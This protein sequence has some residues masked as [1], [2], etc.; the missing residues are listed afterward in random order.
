MMT[1]YIT[2]TSPYARMARVMVI[3]AGLEDRVL[4]EA[5]PTRTLDTP[6]LDTNPSG[7]V[8]TLVDEAGVVFE[9]SALICAYLDTRAEAPVLASPPDWP[10][11]ILEAKARS[12]LDGIAVWSREARRPAGEQ[13]PTVIAHENA[14]VHRMARIFDGIVATGALDGP[15]DMAQLTLACCFH[16]RSDTRPPG[17]DWRGGNDHLAA[18][19]D[20]FGE[21][22]SMQQTAPLLP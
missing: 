5:V 22:A 2:P 18:W 6:L 4:V 15:F 9:E 16:A 1:L 3:E 11:R 13:S 17:L 21:R 12:L 10:A 19:I 8:P 20:A 14:R 7:R